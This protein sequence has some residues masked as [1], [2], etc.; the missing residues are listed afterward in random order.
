M[1]VIACKVL[2]DMIMMAADT[3]VTKGDC[4]VPGLVYSKIKHVGEITFAG[5]GRCDEFNLLQKYMES[6]S[7]PID[8]NCIPVYM[9]GFYKWRDSLSE[10]I[11][12]APEDR[13]ES[14][15]HYV[16]IV[17]GRVFVIGGLVCFELAPGALYATGSG[18]EY[19]MGA[20]GAG[21]T[22]EE[23]VRISCKYDT[24]CSEPIDCFN[25]SRIKEG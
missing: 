1:T 4:V 24:G 22:P 6:N 3:Q 14:N 21:A 13:S 20:M 12:P 11:K 2:D 17:R 18:E 19:A 10:W 23:A 15:N 8:A 5:S 25:A 16:I 7:V 9:S